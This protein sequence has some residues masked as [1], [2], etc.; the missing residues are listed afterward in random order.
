MKRKFNNKKT[1]I[2]SFLMIILIIGAATTI[3]FSIAQSNVVQNNFKAASIDTEIEENIDANLTKEVIVHNT[4]KAN[5][6]AFVRVRISCSPEEIQDTL[7]LNMGEGSKWQDG[8][9]GFYYYLEAVVPDGYTTPLLS[10]VDSDVLKANHP[11]VKDFDIIVYQEA[12]VA[13][14]GEI[15]VDM[16]KKAFDLTK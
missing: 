10:R 1:F 16:L 6:S 13:G 2:A 11:D 12:V 4:D 14:E 8:G 9:D 7:V 5:S 15:T 3:A